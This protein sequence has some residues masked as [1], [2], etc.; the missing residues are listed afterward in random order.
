[1]AVRA[2]TIEYLITANDD[3][4]S[5]AI[6]GAQSKITSFGDVV[7][8]VLG[9]QAIQAG[10][11]AIKNGF[12]SVIDT[13]MSFDSSMSQVAA[14]MGKSMEEMESEVGSVDLA[15]GTFSGNLREYAQE[16]GR[17]TAFSATEAADALNYMALAGYDTQTSMET[18]P[19]V[20][21][22]AAAGGFDLARAS[23][24]VTDTQTAF[25][26][27]I[28]RTAQM[29]DE[30]A[31]AASTGNTSVE[32]LGDAFLVVGGLAKNLNGGFV[33]LADG[34]KAPVD[35]VQ[36]LEV[37]LT[38]MANAGVKGS[39]AG[40][41]MRNM[42]LKLSS[43]T[44]KGVMALEELGISVFDA[45]G[46]MRSL[47]DV[48]GDLSLTF[49]FLSQEEKL[50]VI[51][52][53]FNTRDIASAEALLSAASYDM[54]KLG[55][56]VKKTGVN[57]DAYFAR[58]DIIERGLEMEDVVNYATLALRD[59]DGSV[60]DAADNLS[61]TYSMSMEDAMKITQ[62]ISDELPNARSEWDKIGESIL[63][64][65]GAAQQMADTQL[66]N[67]AG[68]VTLFK[69]ALEGAQIAISDLVV[70]ALRG[71]VSEGTTLLSELTGAIQEGGVGGALEYL[72]GRFE[73]LLMKADEVFPG[74]MT[75]WETLKNIFGTVVDWISS[76]SKDFESIFESIKG[77][78]K[79]FVD[80]VKAIWDNFGKDIMRI[81][82]AAWNYVKT[83]I[84]TTI[85][86]IKDI[87]DVVT[88]IIEGDWDKVWTAIGDIVKNI[89]ERIKETINT[90]L[91]VIKSIISAAWT[92]VKNTISNA[93][94]AVK[95]KIENVFNAIRDFLKSI[96]D[97]INSLTGGALD[98]IKNAISDK[99]NAAKQTVT[100]VFEA[101]RDKIK[102]T[103]EKA[104]DIVKSA[105]DKIRSFFKFE[106]SL[107]KLKLPHLT[108]TGE[109]SLM[110]PSTPSF[111]IE[112]Y[113]KAYNNAYLF[114]KPTIGVGLGFGDGVGGEMVVGENYLQKK[115]GDA[116]EERVGNLAAKMEQIYEFMQVYF[117][118]FASM[119]MVLDSG[120]LVGSI[121]PLMDAELGRISTRKER[122]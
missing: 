36:E 60:E 13:G 62:A 8:G 32:Q 29:V 120:E 73:G 14:T 91:E 9:A 104:R 94:D 35:G 119:Q 23:D 107:P 111:S 49:E 15:W 85:N 28:E 41:H 103:I 57:F 87:I 98:N 90:V 88:G 100:N 21:N 45:E 78:F 81:A 97:K 110:P 38:A 101:I 11:N 19:N 122:G 56:A 64:A 17:N 30:M 6:S 48:M 114:S 27:S 72:Q 2:G 71:F 3:G 59:F 24:M 54:K 76:K 1:M 66:D 33:T 93:V 61:K 116:M 20:L 70:P 50:N 86:I 16:M 96:W 63:G 40:T 7:K 89:W 79:S 53:L 84:E 113:K 22:L 75:L 42:L 117:P 58:P 92:V 31:K 18:L 12:K 39:E 106:W 46:N 51:S 105:I 37:A 95:S 99:L 34:T 74:I 82:D 10:F 26:I 65:S 80:V 55:D 52:D 44:E 121:A 102:N 77:L 43:P 83:F 118:T 47:N 5:S 68:D 112:W 115:I 108:I 4:L 67:L 69:S 109:F 25:G